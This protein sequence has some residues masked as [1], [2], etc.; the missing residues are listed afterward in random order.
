MLYDIHLVEM[1]LCTSCLLKTRYLLVGVSFIHGNGLNGEIKFGGGGGGGGGG[2]SDSAYENALRL[3]CASCANE[4][5][6]WDI[7][8]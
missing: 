8:R 7:K 1:C 6:V 2:S 4:D 3:S 5:I